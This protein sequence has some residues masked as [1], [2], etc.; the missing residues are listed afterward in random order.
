MPNMSM[1]KNPMPTQEP[2]VR[3]KN[4]NEVA[5]GYTEEQAI[6]EAKRRLSRKDLYSRFYRQGCRGQ[7]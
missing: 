7:I 2:E 3:N 1:K 4:F 5:L 6:D